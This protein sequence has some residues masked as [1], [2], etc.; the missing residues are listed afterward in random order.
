MAS[1]SLR[2]YGYC[3]NYTPLF[4]ERLFRD[5]AYLQIQSRQQIARILICQNLEK[6]VHD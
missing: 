2:F 1:L 3:N 4:L 5:Y 6:T